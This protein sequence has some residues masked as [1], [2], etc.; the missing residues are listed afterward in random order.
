MA[1]HLS[2]KADTKIMQTPAGLAVLSRE[3]VVGNGNDLLVYSRFPDATGRYFYQVRKFGT[4]ARVDVLDARHNLIHNTGQYLSWDLARAAI[5]QALICSAQ[6]TLEQL[7]AF[8]P[9]E[10]LG[11][12]AR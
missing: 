6:E 3:H 4:R 9:A 11:I 7:T 1:Y 8:I 2:E 12:T 5:V 10:I